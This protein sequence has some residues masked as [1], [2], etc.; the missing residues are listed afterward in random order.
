M[1]TAV[2]CRLRCAD[3]ILYIMVAAMFAACVTTI[4]SMTGLVSAPVDGCCLV[5]EHYSMCEAVN[6]ARRMCS[7]VM[8]AAF[9]CGFVVH[10]GNVD[11][12][13]NMALHMCCI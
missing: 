9:A 7:Y 4:V 13:D 12:G 10:V 6:D 1:P 11:D 2:N 8:G 3:T 5:V